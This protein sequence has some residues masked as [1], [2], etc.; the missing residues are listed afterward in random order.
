[1]TWPYTQDVID[2]SIGRLRPVEDFSKQ[3]TD[4][5]GRRTTV[6]EEYCPSARRQ[7]SSPR[8][9]ASPLQGA[10]RSE[11]RQ[12][13]IGDTDVEEFRLWPEGGPRSRR[14]RRTTGAALQLS[15]GC[16]GVL[17]CRRQTAS[18]MF[19]V[20]L[21]RHIVTVAYLPLSAKDVGCTPR[22]IVMDLL[23]TKKRMWGSCMNVARRSRLTS[24]HS[25]DHLRCARR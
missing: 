18:Q 7:K 1:M 14:Q 8:L 17:L 10:P 11:T 15:R 19:C 4:D 23:R 16:R 13:M 2:R 22:H 21:S 12:M 6:E 9:C 3:T 20:L 24:A 25:G 5:R